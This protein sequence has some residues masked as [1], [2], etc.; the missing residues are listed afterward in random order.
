MSELHEKIRDMAKSNGSILEGMLLLASEIEEL[1][2]RLNSPLV[3]TVF[4]PI[5]ALNQLSDR[6]DKLEKIYNENK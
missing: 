5:P 4:D 2:E 1:K 3:K 6:L